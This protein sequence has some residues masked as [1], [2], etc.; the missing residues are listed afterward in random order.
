MSTTTR[1]PATVAAKPAAPASTT[2]IPVRD[3]LGTRAGTQR[4]LRSRRRPSPWAYIRIEVLTTLRRPDTIF[5]TI[6]MPL[7][8]YLLFGT[9]S[10]FSSIDVGHGNV[11]ATIMVNMSVYS[12]AIAA[13]SVAASA[14]VEQAGGWGRQIALTPGGMRR[15]V[16]TKLVTA[17]TV[18]TAPVV[19]IFITGALT[20]ALIETPG[21]WLAAFALCLLAAIPFSCFGLAAGLWFPAEGAMGV[22]SASVSVF[23]F[24]GNLFMPLSGVLF[25]LAHYTPLYGPGALAPRPIQGSLVA[26]MDGTVS[27]PLWYTVTNLVAWTTIFIILCLLARRRTTTR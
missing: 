21:R 14:A 16:L 18:A 7:G 6:V 20:G 27:E 13:T 5:F 2:R 10:D 22:A 4:A 9:M 11:S 12:A 25:T 23:A 15:Y 24:L 19:L 8:M 3:S 17:L 26:T 1:Q